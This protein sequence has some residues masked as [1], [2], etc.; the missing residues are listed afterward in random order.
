[1]CFS[2]QI[3]PIFKLPDHK[4]G[5]FLYRL[6]DFSFFVLDFCLMMKTPRPVLQVLYVLY[7]SVSVSFGFFLMKI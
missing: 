1:M 6:S 3:V 4:S 5:I 2:T 7:F